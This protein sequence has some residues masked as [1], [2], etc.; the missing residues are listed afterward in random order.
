[1]TDSPSPRQRGFSLM[2]LAVVMAILT[3]LLGGLLP[4]LT[5][6]QELRARQETEHALADL[7]E[8]LL[9]FAVVHGR[10]PCPAVATAASGSAGAGTEART[11][12]HC[13]CVDAASEVAASGGVAC[14]ANSVGGVVPWA[15][16]GL[17]ETDAWGRRYTYRVAARFGRDPGQSSFGC[18]SSPDPNPAPARAGFALCTPGVI[19]IESAAVGG[20]ALVSYGVPAIVVS[21]GRNG[22]GAYTQPGSPLPSGNA[23]EAE[24]S[25][26]DAAFVANTAIDDQLVWVP[27]NLLMNRMIAAGML[28]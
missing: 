4:T 10:L 12:G 1:M 28:P 15:T 25:D 20:T 6:Q 16:L 24:N 11:G 9:G 26:G 7:R 22:A 14:T 2:E 23:D 27:V 13:A 21:H 18:T 17:P 8:A 5:A 19:T 3:L